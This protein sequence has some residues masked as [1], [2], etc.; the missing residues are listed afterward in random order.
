MIRCAFYLIIPISI[1]VIFNLSLATTV[2]APKMYLQPIPGTNIFDLPPKNAAK[3]FKSC[4]RHSAE[5]NQYWTPSEEQIRIVD[6]KIE[7][8]LPATNP[9]Q[10][11]FEV[12][13]LYF[14]LSEGAKETNIYAYIFPASFSE[15]LTLDFGGNKLDCLK[16]KSIYQFDIGSLELKH[17]K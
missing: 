8:E 5:L 17:L 2:I 10:D 16:I 12:I 15:K 9:K 4:E 14:G 13:K 7:A 3:M 11:S 1:L 6:K